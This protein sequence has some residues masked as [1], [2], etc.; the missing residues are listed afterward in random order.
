M[1]NEFC[2]GWSFGQ[3]CELAADTGYEGVEIAPFTLADSIQDITPALR[4]ELRETAARH[5]LQIVGLHWLLAG[6][7]EFHLNSPDPAVRGRTIDCLKAEIELCA[8]I[9]GRKLVIGSPRQRDVPAGQT[10]R[11]VWDRTVRTFRE[12][13]LHAQGPG[14]CLCLEPLAPDE[15]N[16]ICTAAEARRM[17]EEVNRPAFRMMLDVKAMASEKEPMREI[18]LS[19]APYLAHFHANDASKQGPGFGDTDFVPIAAAL[20][21]A[22]YDGYVS[23]EVFDFS[24]GPEKIARESLRYLREAFA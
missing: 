19:S 8:D 9:G 3:V 20:R 15:T 17:V 4:R 22:G 7:Q 2:E 12:L 24:A 11:Q 21:E 14:V 23:V 6:P 18:I 1:C 5:R 10:Y 16:F 13:A